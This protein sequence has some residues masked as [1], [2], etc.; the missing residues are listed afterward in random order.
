MN[1]FGA[2]ISQTPDLQ[3]SQEGQRISRDRDEEEKIRKL[4]EIMYSRDYRSG[5]PIIGSELISEIQESVEAGDF[6]EL[7]EK[8]L[9]ALPLTEGLE[10]GIYAESYGIPIN[11]EGLTSDEVQRREN[12][13]LSKLRNMFLTVEDSV[14]RGNVG[15]LRDAMLDALSKPIR[16]LERWDFDN[17]ASWEKNKRKALLSQYQREN[18]QKLLDQQ[19]TLSDEEVNKKIDQNISLLRKYYEERIEKIRKKKDR[20]LELDSHVKSRFIFD[21]AFRMRQYVAHDRDLQANMKQSIGLGNTEPDGPHWQAFFQVEI[22]WGKAVDTALRELVKMGY[23]GFYQSNPDSKTFKKFILRGLEA[24]QID[25]KSRMDVIWAAWR[26]FC[27]MELS[28]KF[29][30]NVDEEGEMGFNANPPYVGDLSSWLSHPEEHKAVE[31]GWNHETYLRARDDS[32]WNGLPIKSRTSSYKAISHSGHPI[33]IGHLTEKS[34]PTDEDSC[35][36]AVFGKWK[37]GN[38][39]EF[40]KIQQGPNKGKTLWD[41]W[42]EG[43]ISFA[44]IRFPWV[45]TDYAG[46]KITSDEAPSGSF[47]YWLLQRG[48]A[49]GVLKETLGIPDL[50]TMDSITYCERLRNWQKLGMVKPGS[51]GKN[52]IFVKLIGDISFYNRPPLRFDNKLINELYYN[53]NAYR[54]KIGDFEAGQNYLGTSVKNIASNA[55]VTGLIDINEFN[56]LRK[57][58]VG[59][60]LRGALFSGR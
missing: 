3:P 36:I 2:P 14:D 50:N 54:E 1:E 55:L 9:E 7:E 41:I 29:A 33:I 27:L 16:E 40:A 24:S 28:G 60:I 5:L 42:W 34:T 4:A 31:Y 49:L 12:N 38:Y 52:P 20:L 48:R 26:Q 25:G 22:K 10:F 51:F 18:L 57:F 30:M 21:Q 47:G 32:K 6:D 37:V 8:I 45:D 46:E 19:E 56:F 39:L 58:R 53:A 35:P 23:E 17:G 15:Y 11:L 59:L 43:Y 44:D 13:V